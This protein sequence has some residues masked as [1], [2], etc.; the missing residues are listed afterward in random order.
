MTHKIVL[1]ERHGHEELKKT[2]YYIY[3]NF[4]F[5]SSS[6]SRITT[7]ILFILKI[8]EHELDV[9]LCFLFF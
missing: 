5:I 1:K 8:N 4:I 7:K 6:I 2:I 3:L 9:V